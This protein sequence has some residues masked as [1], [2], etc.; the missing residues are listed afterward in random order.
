MGLNRIS[1]RS[2]LLATAAFGLVT[3]CDATQSSQQ[4]VSSDG[5]P[6]RFVALEW[7]LVEDLL[8]LGIQPVGGDI[9][10]RF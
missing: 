10:R 9:S 4:E 8:A 3:A 6:K 2:F 7:V 1:R 5:I